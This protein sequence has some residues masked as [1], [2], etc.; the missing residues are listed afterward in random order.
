MADVFKARQTDL[1]RF[2]AMKMIRAGNANPVL[3]TRF[4]KEA[5]SVARLRHPNVV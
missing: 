2:V 5:E 3:R 4:R 1:K